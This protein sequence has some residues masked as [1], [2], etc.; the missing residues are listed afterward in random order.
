MSINKK[1][2]TAQNL[3]EKL[4]LSV[5]TIWRYTRE[6]KIPFID[7]GNRQ[8]RYKLEEVVKSLASSRVR[9][10]G[11]EYTEDSEDFTYEDYLELPEELGYQFEVLEGTLIKEPSPNVLHQRVSRRLHRILEDYFWEV[12]PEGE[13]FA[14]PLDVTLSDNNVVQPDL[15]FVAGIQK[16]IIK[17]NR[18]DGSP[19]LAV[20]IISPYNIRKDRLR[21]MQ[22]YQ[23]SGIENYWILDP[24]EK[25][26]ECFALR[27][28]IYALLASGMDEDIL[29]HPDFKGLSIELGDLW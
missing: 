29:E 22:I 6:G 26:M 24:A 21:K 11:N 27:D 12:D 1:M 23:N 9:E 20:E 4:D 18:I 17:E 3:A 2:I 15:F 7:L 16:K 5:E 25:T 19:I 28:G 14:A 8:Y 10:T 13:V